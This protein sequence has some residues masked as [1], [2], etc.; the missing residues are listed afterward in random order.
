MKKRIFPIAP[1]HHW[2]Q[3]SGWEEPK[4]V[5]R[6]WLAGLAFVLFL[7][8]GWRCYKSGRVKVRSVILDASFELSMTG[9]QNDL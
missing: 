6:A 9:H 7:G 2:L 1:F 8:Y 5:A 4:I 3:L